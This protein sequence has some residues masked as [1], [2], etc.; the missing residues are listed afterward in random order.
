MPYHPIVPKGLYI[1]FEQVAIT[2]GKNNPTKLP[3]IG[4]RLEADPLKNK[5]QDSDV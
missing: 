5:G 1:V 2:N 4:V 3:A